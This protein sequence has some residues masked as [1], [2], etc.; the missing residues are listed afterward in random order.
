M[1]TSARLNP[2]TP[3][4][5]SPQGPSNGLEA[6]QQ[7]TRAA[8]PLGDGK[9]KEA[10][11]RAGTQVAGDEGSSGPTSQLK[12]DIIFGNEDAPEKL[13]QLAR[14]GTFLVHG[15]APFVAVN[16]DLPFHGPKV[17]LRRSRVVHIRGPAEADWFTE[18]ALRGVLASDAV[19]VNAVGALDFDSEAVVETRLDGNWDGEGG[20]E[21]DGSQGEGQEQGQGQMR[22]MEWRFFD[23]V[24]ARACK[25]ALRE[26]YGRRLH[27]QNAPDPCWDYVEM[28]NYLRAKGVGQKALDGLRRNPFDGDNSP[29]TPVYPAYFLEE[30]VQSKEGTSIEEGTPGPTST[31]E[32]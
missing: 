2:R 25:R 12:A 31:K 29:S 16:T 13:T 30:A 32:A 15:R 17:E 6:P 4:F 27:I 14:R 11:T 26:H 20:G 28:T 23:V 7:P 21:G 19:A 5:P 18:G 9:R 8:P 10:G 1:I 22:L 3:S 24:Q